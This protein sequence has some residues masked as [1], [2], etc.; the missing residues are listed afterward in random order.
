MTSVNPLYRSANLATNVML[1]IKLEL[2]AT[3]Q[4]KFS[5]K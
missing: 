5:L 3:V 4:L 2:S 1:Y